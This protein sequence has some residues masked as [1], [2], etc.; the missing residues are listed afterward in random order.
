MTGNPEYPLMLTG[1]GDGAKTYRLKQDVTLD[2][3]DDDGSWT[4]DVMYYQAGQ[5]FQVWNDPPQRIAGGPNT[6]HLE[7][8]NGDWMEI[9]P[10]HFAEWFEQ[11]GGGG[12]EP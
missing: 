2:R 5:L 11:V 3:Y 8:D 10:E 4:E 7:S 9:T 12:D 6:I 1:P